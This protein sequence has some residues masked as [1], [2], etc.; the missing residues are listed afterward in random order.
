VA[1]FIVVVAVAPVNIA[2]PVAIN[3]VA[4]L[5]PVRSVIVRPV[6]PADVAAGYVYDGSDHSQYCHAMQCIHSF[7]LFNAL[8]RS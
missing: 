2:V 8:R 5:V 6:I 1:V 3:P 4:V 7:F